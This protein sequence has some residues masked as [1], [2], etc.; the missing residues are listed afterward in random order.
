MKN[1]TT[2]E[3]VD[4]EELITFW[5]SSRSAVRISIQTPDPDQLHLRR[6]LRSPSFKDFFRGRV[7]ENIYRHSACVC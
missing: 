3:S 7:N 5:K 1:F 4:E 6:G 2:D